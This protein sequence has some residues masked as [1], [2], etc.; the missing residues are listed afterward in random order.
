MFYKSANSSEFGKKT[1]ESTQKG[2]KRA[3]ELGVDR[4]A[5]GG[6]TGAFPHGE[7]ALEMKLMVRLGADWKKVLSWG[8]LG[9]YNC[10]K[11]FPLEGDGSE[12]SDADVWVAD[13]VVKFGCIK[14]GWAADIIALDGDLERDFEAT[15]DRV[16]FVM[17]SGRVY[18]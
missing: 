14:P 11:P 10:I 17:K 4:I 3:L 18:K 5:C 1:W 7:N 2:F 8:T 6:D 9:G 16:V 15:L 12:E 13:H